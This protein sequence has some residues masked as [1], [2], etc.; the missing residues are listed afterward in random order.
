[1]VRAA[2]NALA[3]SLTDAEALHTVLLA[4]GPLTQSGYRSANDPTAKHERAMKVED[5]MTQRTSK[6]YSRSHLGD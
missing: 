2:T 1:M 6:K 4:R 3:R 5:S